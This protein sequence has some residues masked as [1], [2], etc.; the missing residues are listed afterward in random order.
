MH[1]SEGES[2]LPIV[3]FGADI[4]R[5]PTEECERSPFRLLEMLYVYLILPEQSGVFVCLFE[6][7][8]SHFETGLKS[9]FFKG[10]LTCFLE[11]NLFARQSRQSS[12]DAVGHT[13]LL[14]FIKSLRESPPKI[15]I[16]P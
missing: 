7:T 4:Y 5:N 13:L 3:W 16:K 9:H 8:Q 11:E 6:D 12:L 2:I 10:P 15:W 1:A 14:R